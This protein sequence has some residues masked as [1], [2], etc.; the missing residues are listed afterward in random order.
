[1]FDSSISETAQMLAPFVL[2][3][4]GFLAAVDVLVRSF[5]RPARAADVFRWGTF[6]LIAASVAASFISVARQHEHH[7]PWLLALIV[8]PT[9]AGTACLC[10]AI[11]LSQSGGRI[12]ARNIATVVIAIGV[13]SIFAWGFLAT[14]GPRSSGISSRRFQGLYNLRNVGLAIQNFAALNEDQLPAPVK[15]EPPLSWR[16][17]V[18]P[19]LD[20]S[21]V[22]KMYR[23]DLGWNVEPNASIARIK[24][25]TYLCPEHQPQQDAH[26]RY[27][28]SFELI[29]GPGTI[30]PPEGP[31][32]LDDVSQG[33]GLSTTLLLV[34]ACGQNIVWTEPRDLDLTPQPQP[35]SVQPEPPELKSL[36]SWHH[37]GGTNVIFAD[38]TTR[39][40]SKSIN[41][42]VLKALTTP[43][44]GEDIPPSSY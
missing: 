40:L 17:A 42:K 6:A 32:S 20:N 38:G 7:A 9:F 18:L 28:S 25:E 22:F 10:I 5:R 27:Y 30:F 15:G 8:Y 11:R 31:L 23:K 16:V 19:A 3:V 13:L 41:P 4:G 2:V 33:D 12:A 21:Q 34:E 39:Y 43:R 1:M 37:A 26:G 36:M 29:T 44:G 24:L 14:F 35:G